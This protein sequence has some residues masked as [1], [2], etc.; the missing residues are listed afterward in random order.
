MSH[1]F[2][3]CPTIPLF[4][5]SVRYCDET[6]FTFQPS[7][8]VSSWFQRLNLHITR[9]L[10]FFIFPSS[11]R[12]CFRPLRSQITLDNALYW[13]LFYLWCIAGNPSII[14]GDKTPQKVVSV[15]FKT[16]KALLRNVQPNA[17]LIISR[18]RGIHHSTLSHNNNVRVKSFRWDASSLS[19]LEHSQ[20]AIIHQDFTHFNQSIPSISSSVVVVF[21]RL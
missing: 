18:K 7:A 20:S 6:E 2:S 4:R 3:K 1:V 14:V 13:L 9:R 15:A 11:R 10:L 5:F 19:Y 8:N 12:N 17:F 16:L 21:G